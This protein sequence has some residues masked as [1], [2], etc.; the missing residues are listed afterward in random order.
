M[1]RPRLPYGYES[2]IELER[3]SRC[4]DEA[5][6][7]DAG[8]LLHG[9]AT[10]RSSDRGGRSR[11]ECRVGKQAE[12]VRVALE[13][14]EPRYEL[15]VKIGFRRDRVG[16]L[17]EC[18]SGA[19][20]AQPVE[21]PRTLTSPLRR[22]SARVHDARDLGGAESDD[23][24]IEILLASH[25]LQIGSH[26]LSP[27]AFPAIDELA[28]A[29]GA[30]DREVARR[31]F[32]PGVETPVETATSCDE[33]ALMFELD[34]V[35]LDLPQLFG[36]PAR[37]DLRPT[38]VDTVL[39][40]RELTGG[41]DPIGLDA[42]AWSRPAKTSERGDAARRKTLEGTY[43]RQSRLFQS[44]NAAISCSRSGDGGSS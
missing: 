27:L 10:K 6:R 31:V 18:W 29:P 7:L 41:L 32:V 19:D 14:L 36:Q 28:R 23:R 25:A 4:E 21:Q 1:N 33:N 43:A 2:G 13:V 3:H 30:P 37:Q 40:H 39:A 34:A 9:R 15:V 44:R 20:G 26:T 8:H 5:T 11:E 24:D 16:P 22:C 42:I 35:E 38:G 12:G 17:R